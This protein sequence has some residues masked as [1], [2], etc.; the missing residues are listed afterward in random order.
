LLHILD[1]HPSP[2]NINH[3]KSLILASDKR[4][5]LKYYPIVDDYAE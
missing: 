3:P 4:S 2:L 5:I 1:I